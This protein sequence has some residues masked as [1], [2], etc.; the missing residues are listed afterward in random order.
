MWSS[1]TVDLEGVKTIV[2]VDLEGVKFLESVNFLETWTWRLTLNFLDDL[3]LDRYFMGPLRLNLY[4][5][6]VFSDGRVHKLALKFSPTWPESFSGQIHQNDIT[7]DRLKINGIFSSRKVAVQRDI[8]IGL[9]AKMTLVNSQINNNCNYWLHHHPNWIYLLGLAK[10][11][12]IIIHIFL[13]RWAK[14]NLWVMQWNLFWNQVCEKSHLHNHWRCPRLFFK[15]LAPRSWN[16][17]NWKVGGLT[18]D[19]SCH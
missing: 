12:T 14:W 17:L 2:Q 1:L 10:S 11:K 19:L 8:W 7:D 16:T 3:E 9:I 15:R 6:D 18:G 4:T 5:T 13:L